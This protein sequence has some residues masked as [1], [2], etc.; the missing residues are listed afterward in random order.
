MIATSGDTDVNSRLSRESAQGPFP[1]NK[2]VQ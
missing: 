2:D 1:S